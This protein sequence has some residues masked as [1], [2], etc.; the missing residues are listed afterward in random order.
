MAQLW[1]KTT[2]S[3]L[4]ML[5]AV[6]PPGLPLGV[7]APAS[8][9]RARRTPAPTEVLLENLPDPQTNED[10]WLLFTGD[11]AAV[12]VDGAPQNLGIYHL[13]DGQEVLVKGAG[14][15]VLTTEKPPDEVPAPRHRERTSSARA[16]RPRSTRVPTRSNA[17]PAGSGTTSATTCRAGPTSTAPTAPCAPSRPTSTA[18][19][20]RIPEG[21]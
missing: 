3:E 19:C 8:R 7:P 4:T 18:A 2:N 5:P 15:V 6:R 12:W 1:F 11:T 17:P 20:K 9:I 21:L 16:A 13:A 10:R 14:V